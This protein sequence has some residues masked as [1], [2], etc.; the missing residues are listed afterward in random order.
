MQKQ[1]FSV[2]RGLVHTWLRMQMLRS[3][4][5]YLNKR[6]AVVLQFSPGFHPGIDIRQSGL[7]QQH[8]QANAAS[9]CQAL[10]RS[11]RQDYVA[12]LQI[13]ASSC[14]LPLALLV[15]LWG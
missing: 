2:C 6:Y 8:L 9:T 4:D 12:C 3:V 1:G 10:E 11:I 13:V 5:L 15:D 14:V 7:Q